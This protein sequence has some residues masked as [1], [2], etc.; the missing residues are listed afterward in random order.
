MQRKQQLAEEKG[1]TSNPV[2]SPQLNIAP[3]TLK[4][5]ETAEKTLELLQ[6]QCDR[7]L[8]D[9]EDI[10]DDDSVIDD[11]YD[12]AN[13]A[14]QQLDKLSAQF[15]KAKTDPSTKQEIADNIDSIHAQLKEI[16]GTLNELAQEY[17]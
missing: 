1:P 2:I 3:E 16:S 4:K 13:D 17:S 7:I 8:D 14:G 5:I 11:D 10:T 15:E 12:D 9:I 6:N